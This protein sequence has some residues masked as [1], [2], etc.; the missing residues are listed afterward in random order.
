[1][2]FCAGLPTGTGRQRRRA[3]RRPPLAGLSGMPLRKA[4]GVC[5]PG[6]CPPAHK[7]PAGFQAGLLPPGLKKT[8]EDFRS[9]GKVCDDHLGLLLLD[10]L[11]ADHL[12]EHNGPT[13]Q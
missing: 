4:S 6:I 11:G 1:M 9:T 2:L 12:V 8:E 10:K 5:R 3:G 13:G 7:L